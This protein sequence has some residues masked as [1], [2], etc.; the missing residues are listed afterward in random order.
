MNE[1]TRWWLANVADVRVHRSTKK[2][3]LDAH[4]EEQPHLLPL[5]ACDYD[6]GQV[7]YRVVDV[8]GW[9]NY[10]SNQY[11]VPW[12]LV[13][14]LLPVRVTEV[15]LFVY[16]HRIQELA[17]HPLLKGPTGQRREDP[18]HRPPRDH[19]EQTALLRQRF[20]ELGEVA[21][22]FLEG[23]LLQRY[24]KHQA[25]RV[26]LLLHTYR[27][28][29]LLA[30]MERAVRYHAYTLSSLERIL[31]LQAVPKPSW[32]S[33]GESQQET[34]QKLTETEPIEPRS[35]AEYQYLLPEEND[36]DAEEHPKPAE[37]DPPTPAD[38]EDPADE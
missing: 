30:A 12:G 2:R 13:G 3:P 16:D 36:S 27:R 8:E 6:T 31:S 15:E 33:L 18:A 32:Q 10:G 17:R 26:L 34:L 25:R 22:C 19:R 7:V 38:A 11:S 37:P 20:A 9:I 29:D 14:E 1:V 23:L 21:S 24:G 28:E 35:S 4:A 5:P